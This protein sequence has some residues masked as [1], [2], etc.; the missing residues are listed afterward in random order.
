MRK[1]KLLCVQEIQIPTARVMMNEYLQQGYYYPRIQILL[2]LFLK[3]ESVMNLRF[4][5]LISKSMIN[6]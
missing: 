5:N 3:R 2:I 6:N 1:L 4:I